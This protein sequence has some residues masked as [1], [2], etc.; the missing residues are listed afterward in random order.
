MLVQ[1]SLFIDFLESFYGGGASFCFVNRHLWPRLMHRE[2]QHPQVQNPVRFFQRPFRSGHH[3]PEGKDPPCPCLTLQNYLGAR[4]HRHSF[5]FIHIDGSSPASNS[6]PFPAGQSRPK[7]PQ[8][9]FLLP[10]PFALGLPQ[11]W[12]WCMS[13]FNTCAIG[14]E[15]RCILRLH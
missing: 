7:V 6:V 9:T 1:S 8:W 12:Q 10:T 11:L 4:L 13:A 5:L 3:Y 15:V 2:L 14:L